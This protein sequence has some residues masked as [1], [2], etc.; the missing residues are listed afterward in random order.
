MLAS[1]VRPSLLILFSLAVANGQTTPTSDV[2]SAIPKRLGDCRAVS[3][4]C[5]GY[6]ACTGPTRLL[7]WH[8][9]V[10]SNRLR[11]RSWASLCREDPH[12]F[13]S[14]LLAHHS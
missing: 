9:R 8:G 7:F 3:Q 4:R 6:I 11:L 2:P 14:L 1:F 5:T 10:R 13:P 12:S